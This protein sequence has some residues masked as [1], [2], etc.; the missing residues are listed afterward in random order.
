[1]SQTLLYRL[2]GF[3]SLPKA[4]R[5]ILEQEGIV[6]VE[7][8]IGGWMIF[9]NF[10]APG[11]RY[12]YRRRWFTGSLVVTDRRFAGFAVS[13]PVINVPL[14]GPHLAKLETSVEDEG[15][16][17]VVSFESSDFH[18]DW[19]GTIECRFSTPKAPLFLERIDAERRE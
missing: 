13:K 14:D 7:E 1:M 2:F 15:S 19:S 9:R 18:D 6:L 3:G 16:V 11:R 17:L 5:P 12:S 4:M 8:G 10:R